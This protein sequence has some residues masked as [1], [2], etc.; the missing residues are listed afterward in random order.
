MEKINQ[1]IFASASAKTKAFQFDYAEVDGVIGGHCGLPFSQSIAGRLWHNSGAV[2]MPA[3]DG[4]RNVWFSI[5]T[6]NDSGLKIQHRALE[7]DHL[8]AAAKIRTAGLP[9]E[10]ANALETGLWPSCDILPATEIRERGGPLGEGSISWPYPLA[11][12]SRL[13]AVAVALWPQ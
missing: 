12:K 10:Y 1:F 6:P 8:A 11:S 7:Y 3:N 2:G 5:I 4:T 13:P 9:N